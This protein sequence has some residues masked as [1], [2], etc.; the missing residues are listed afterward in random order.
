[1]DAYYTDVVGNVSTSRFRT[2]KR[3]ALLEAKPRYPVFGGW[4]YPFTIGWN[5]DAKNFLR[6]TQAGGYVLNVPF[7]EGP[8]QAE[9]VE[10]KEVNIQV[11]LP[12]G[13]E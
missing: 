10:Y 9:G 8:K 5:S 1:M 7:M 11:L 4:K 13:A 3:E 2:N 6:K 12:E